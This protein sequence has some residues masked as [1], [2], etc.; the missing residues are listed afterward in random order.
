MK[1]KEVAKHYIGCE[2]FDSF[3]EEYLKLTAR[4][5]QGY[6]DG[7][8]E[9]EAMQIKPIL[10]RLEDMDIETIKEWDK[11]TRLHFDNQPDGYSLN[12]EELERALSIVRK[13]GAAA[14]AMSEIV[15]LAFA[16]LTHFLCSK[17][18]DLFGLIESGEA[19][20][21]KTVKKGGDGE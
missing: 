16:H 14:F 2:V 7:L 13:K 11:Y 10:H 15:P 6:M 5:L 12:T 19:I 1:F 3:N 20:D 8:A 21:A 4:A 18:Y 17:S 9:D